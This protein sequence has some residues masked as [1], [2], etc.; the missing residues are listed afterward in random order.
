M[1]LVDGRLVVSRLP[2][3]SDMPLSVATAS[4][5]TSRATAALPHWPCSLE[6]MSGVGH[7]SLG[8]LV[9][10]PSFL[11]RVSTLSFDPELSASTDRASREFARI[12][13]RA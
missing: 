3:A 8:S 5:S 6:H 9:L 7:G 10:E 12:V 2:N 1:S 4:R 11:V 13:T